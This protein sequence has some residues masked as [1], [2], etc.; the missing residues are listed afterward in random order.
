M[1][2]SQAEQ[3]FRR[4][5][6]LRFRDPGCRAAR[7]SSP[8]SA[9]RQARGLSEWLGRRSGESHGEAERSTYSP[10]SR[11]QDHASI[12]V[13]V[14]S[15]MWN[16]A[17]LRSWLTTV[18]PTDFAGLTKAAL[19]YAPSATAHTGLPKSPSHGF[20]QRSSSTASSS[21]VRN[22]DGD[23]VAEAGRRSP[24]REELVLPS[25]PPTGAST[26]LQ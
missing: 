19:A 22:G 16:A 7:I 1:L 17:S 18:T 12:I 3:S 21:L 25:L 8:K 14:H 13:N 26:K 6:N 10:A 11:P 5:L 9:R 23:Q 15:Q 4:G 20:A 2:C 24:A